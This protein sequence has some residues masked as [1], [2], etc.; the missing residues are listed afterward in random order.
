MVG[1]EEANGDVTITPMPLP[2]EI[3][4]T[5]A[6][7]VDSFEDSLSDE[8]ETTCDVME[9]PSNEFVPMSKPDG[10]GN[11][12]LGLTKSQQNST[13]DVA[14]EKIDHSS[15]EL[16]SCGYYVF[17]SV[18]NNGF[19]PCMAQDAEDFALLGE[20]FN[21]DTELSTDSTFEVTNA[22]TSN[23]KAAD[24]AP[25]A[26]HLDTKLVDP[27]STKTNFGDVNLDV[28]RSQFAHESHFTRDKFEA[29]TDHDDNSFEVNTS[30]GQAKCNHM[31]GACGDQQSAQHRRR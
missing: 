30:N 28:C 15:L 8:F 31:V 2:T 22:A 18:E 27:N 19:T 4:G 16:P 23:K 17:V 26:T 25:T 11:N 24:L 13:G 3:D 7:S 20:F 6:T 5:E 10:A 21:P 9:T 14:N 12:N 29:N 1:H